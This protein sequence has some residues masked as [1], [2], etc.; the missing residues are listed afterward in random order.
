MMRERDPEFEAWVARAKA[1]SFERAMGLCGFRPAK[2]YEAKK[3]RAGPCPACGGRDRF[4]VMPAARKFN[5]RKCGAKGLNALSLALV[6]ERLS[7]LD[8][9]RELTGEDPPRADMRETAEQQAE[10]ARK[11]AE[12]DTR[13]AAE[14]VRRAAEAADYRERERAACRRLWDMGRA[15]TLEKLGRYFSARGILL[16]ASALIREADEVAFFHGE[17]EDERGFRRPRLIHRG[18][19]MLAQMLDNAG[20]FVGLHL[21]YLA[22]DW[23][24]KAAIADPDTGEVLNPK[25]MRGS[26][27]GSHT[28]LRQPDDE[29]I[30]AAQAAGAR[31]RLFIGEGNETVASVGSALK[32]AGRLD[33][34]DHFWGSG[35]LG[36]LGGPADG[37][38][39]HPTLKT[40]KGRAQRLPGPVPDF[41]APGIIIPP[42]VTHLVLLGDGDSERVLTETVLERGRRRYAREGLT[43]GIAM[44][45]DDHDFNDMVRGR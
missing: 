29:A 1:G 33:A 24:G 34:L 12:M 31:I 26:K 44:A 2:G 18:P 19:A 22:P 38:L 28:V 7:F 5:C 17:E 42:Y 8:A 32:R 11:R 14:D 9:C 39:A 37:T 4:S 21:T 30:H 10:R 25:K 40:P 20:D 13:I 41:N 16:P 6:G 43:I 3:D 45:P 36:N 23:C 35:D 27:K 15:P